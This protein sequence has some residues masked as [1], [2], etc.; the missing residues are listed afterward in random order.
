M[1]EILKA[2]RS[3]ADCASI[4]DEKFNSTYERLEESHKTL[5]EAE[6]S[7]NKKVA[8]S[9][10]KNADAI[11][12]HLGVRSSPLRTPSAATRRLCTPLT[13]LPDVQ[14]IVSAVA[15][16][17]KGVEQ[18]PG[19]SQHDSIQAAPAP[20]QARSA[21]GGTTPV[22]LSPLTCLLDR[23]D[24]QN[25]EKKT[26][27]PTRILATEQRRYAEGTV[28]EVCTQVS[29][30]DDLLSTC[31]SECS[32]P[33]CIPSCFADA[34]LTGG[35]A[36]RRGEKDPLHS[37]CGHEADSSFGRARSTT[38]PTCRRQPV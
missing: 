10:L 23:Q 24:S 5:D 12:T 21:F 17:L 1:S 25:D 32:R 18:R 4:D 2:L 14:E 16:R 35:V 13:K 27:E 22:V 8:A 11:G 3:A 15:L 36:C 28:A 9:L 31:C 33:V 20:P 29:F 26:G 38:P 7:S 34:A 30:I 37:R 6:Q 19:F